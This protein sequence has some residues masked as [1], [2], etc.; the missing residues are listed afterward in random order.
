MPPPPTDREEGARNTS[1][2]A[3]APAGAPSP[4]GPW[5]LAAHL[6][7]GP[8]GKSARLGVPSP[9]QCSREPAG[10]VRLV[11]PLGLIIYVSASGPPRTWQGLPAVFGNTLCPAPS[12]PPLRPSA[13]PRRDARG[14]RGGPPVPAP[15][16]LPRT[17]PL[18]PRAR[19]PGL[20]PTARNREVRKDAVAHFKTKARL[21][22]LGAAYARPVSDP[23]SERSRQ[24]TSTQRKRSGLKR[25]R[26]RPAVV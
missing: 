22:A 16:A 26:N 18:Q 25:K 9:S 5:V 21:L 8:T 2:S 24:P 19:R 17:C 6:Y 7:G 23:R 4:A 10:A 13:P 11:P 1:S 20:G 14:V 15:R 12:G 3:L